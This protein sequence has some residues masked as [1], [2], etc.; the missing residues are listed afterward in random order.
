[1]KKTL[2]AHGFKYGL[3]T[4]AFLIAFLFLMRSVGLLHN[5]NLRILNS[6][7]LMTTVFIGIRSYKQMDLA[8]FS[9]LKGAGIGLVIS[10]T[11]GII[12][13]VFVY[14]YLSIDPSLMQA[15]KENEPQ[16]IYMNE[17]GVTALVMIEAIASGLLFTYGSMQFLKKSRFAIA[18]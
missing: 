13:S 18:G 4:V 14:L 6:L 16:G 5:F 2:E 10:L 9:Y 7:F 1:M 11:T 8:N 3:F 17:I 15:I 12:F